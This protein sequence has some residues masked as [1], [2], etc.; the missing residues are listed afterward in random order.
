MTTIS[1]L[2]VVYNPDDDVVNCLNSLNPLIESHDLEIIVIDNASTNG[3]VESLEAQ[4]PNVKFIHSDR[5]RGFGGGNNLGLQHSSGELILSLNP[6]VLINGDAITTLRDTLLQDDTIGIVAPKTTDESGTIA[7]IARAEYTIL[8]LCIK[9]LGLDRLFPKV[10]YSDYP[11]KIQTAT[12]PFEADWLQGSCLLMLRETYDSIGGF[13]EDYF[14][15]MEDADICQRIRELGLSAVYVPDAS[16]VHIGG[17]TTNNYHYIRVRSYH[18][19][20]IH[21]HRKRGNRLGV[22]IL[23]LAF[24]IELLGKIS[25]RTLRNVLS[26]SEVRT[27]HRNA[28]IRTLRELWGY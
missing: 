22:I 4:F 23:K 26:S 17:T 2:I 28:E 9:Y 14:L 10:V 12:S 3:F 16:V 13:D 11:Q 27:R 5:N 1:V 6:D 20:P 19:S 24:T 25:F 8:R 21:Y 18:H 15:Y 7:H